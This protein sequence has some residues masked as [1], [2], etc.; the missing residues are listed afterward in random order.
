[1]LR[2]RDDYEVL[3]AAAPRQP[4]FLLATDRAASGSLVR[5]IRHATGHH[6][7]VKLLATQNLIAKTV[8][9]NRPSGLF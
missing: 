8:K 6:F 3:G 9:V 1:M 7:A 5:S 2:L 4:S